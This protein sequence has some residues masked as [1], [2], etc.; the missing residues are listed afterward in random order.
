MRTKAVD[1]GQEPLVVDGVGGL[2]ELRSTSTPRARISPVVFS[3]IR[4]ETTYLILAPF[5]GTS[6]AP[7]REF[8][9]WP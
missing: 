8:S 6:P 2:P 1:A 5:F 7:R 9:D 3:R 4:Y